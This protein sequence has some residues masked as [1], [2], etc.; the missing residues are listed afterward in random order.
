V[1][2]TDVGKKAWRGKGRA[3]RVGG[4]S[5]GSPMT[6]QAKTTEKSNPDQRI[7]NTV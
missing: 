2:N 3:A 7:R 4:V 5:I 6:R 1:L